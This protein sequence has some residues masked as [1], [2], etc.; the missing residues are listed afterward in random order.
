MTQ[1]IEADKKIESGVFDKYTKK[2]IYKL[3]SKG[4][5]DT[6]DFPVSTGKEAD[7]YR[8][9]TRDDEN[10]AVKIYRIETT[11]FKKKKKYLVHDPRFEE[12][13]S[14]RRG[15]IKQWCKKEYRNLRDAREA[16]VRCPKPI[17]A[18]NNVLVMEYIG[19][20]DGSPAPLLKDAKIEE[21]KKIIEKLKE[22]LDLL[23]EEAGLVHSDFSEFNILIQNQEPVIIDMGQAVSKKHPKAEEFLQR[24]LKNLKKIS[25]Q[26]KFKQD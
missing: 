4:Y 9:T 1:K 13:K 14:S 21:P 22:Y 2:T 6:L 18:I 17:K 16:G 23:Y 12:V 8:G 20:E 26:R 3:Q 19:K 10:V 15:I 5:F 24:D 7:V 25:N 11:R